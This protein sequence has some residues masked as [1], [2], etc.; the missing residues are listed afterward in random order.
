[1]SI[2][3]HPCDEH[4]RNLYKTE[5]KKWLDSADKGDEKKDVPI[6]HEK[7]SLK[8]LI[9]GMQPDSSVTMAGIASSMN[10]SR[11]LSPLKSTPHTIVASTNLEGRYN[12]SKISVPFAP[13][14]ADRKANFDDDFDSAESSEDSESEKSGFP[15][16]NN[17]T[18]KMEEMRRSRFESE[19]SE[20][21]APETLKSTGYNHKLTNLKTEIQAIIP[22]ERET[23]KVDDLTMHAANQLSSVNNFE[24]QKSEIITTYT[25]KL[26]QLQ[27]SQE[28]EFEA[29]RKTLIDSFK[30]NLAEMA[31]DV[32]KA[33]VRENE[34]IKNEFFIE[35][36]NEKAIPKIIIPENKLVPNSSALYPIHLKFRETF[37]TTITELAYEVIQ[38]YNDKEC[39]IRK[40]LEE[41]NL[42]ML[43]DI[44]SNYAALYDKE[45]KRI[46][47]EHKKKLAE[48]LI[49]NEE[50]INDDYK[51]ELEK[52][53]DN[54]CKLKETCDREATK[55][56]K[57]CSEYKEK[58]ENT[59]AEWEKKLNVIEQ[60]YRN[61]E[62]EY[63]KR[64]EKANHVLAQSDN[65]R[66]TSMEQNLSNEI[67]NLEKE[68]RARVL[69]LEKERQKLIEDDQ[70]MQVKIKEINDKK[71][72]IDLEHK[73]FLEKSLIEHPHLIPR[74]ESNVT[75]NGY[76]NYQSLV[77]CIKEESDIE[78]KKPKSRKK[79][80][81]KK[82]ETNICS[83]ESD[84]SY[85]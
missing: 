60:D 78:N 17:E 6:N 67:K 62:S 31:N 29:N 66:E 70:Q 73:K 9:T 33:L 10:P 21:R 59:K 14:I 1:M 24:K 18:D 15:L 75:D 4:Y 46:E 38:E 64:V 45:L 7:P 68:N 53:Q 82:R 3:D 61:K 30:N 80:I 37:S 49:T 36:T 58:I 77:E 44:E 63:L 48:L 16:E 47:S 5:K 81:I 12:D 25:N 69:Q 28:L 55:L 76:G 50:K 2:W 71:Q 42:K 54:I 40:Q 84:N 85:G 74:N 23:Q 72:K 65:V 19:E 27:Q 34:I 11:K 56:E 8:P 39:S 57:I 83:S 79:Y 20:S 35:H 51:N 41:R 26:L 32:E 22:N 43:Q 13:S 52:A